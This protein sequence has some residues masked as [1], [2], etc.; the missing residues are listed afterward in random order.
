[1]SEYTQGVCRDGAAILKDGQPLT[2]EQILEALRERDALAAHVERLRE[3]LGMCRH[4]ACYSVGDSEGLAIQMATIRNIAIEAL[5][6]G[7]D[8]TA[9]M[10]A[11]K[12]SAEQMNNCEMECGAYGTYCKCN[13]EVHQ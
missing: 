12:L 4:H 10:N 5:R 1:M 2:I 7:C 13:D 9:C 8:Q 11:L 3:R 6:E